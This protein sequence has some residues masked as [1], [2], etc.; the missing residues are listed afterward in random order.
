MAETKPSADFSAI[1]KE[2]EKL[3]KKWLEIAV[4]QEKATKSAEKVLT[5]FSETAKVFT[6]I[7]KGLK[8][9]A[10]GL[11]KVLQRQQ[12]LATQTESTT[13]A[14]KRQRVE[15][16]EQ[17]RRDA[18]YAGDL[19][20]RGF[21]QEQI[22]SLKAT[23][24][25]QVTYK[26]AIGRLREVLA[27]HNVGRE[28]IQQIW[29]ELAQGKTQAYT[30]SLRK[31]RDAFYDVK[32]AQEQLGLASRKQQAV[33][34]QEAAAQKQAQLAAEAHT[35]ALRAQE[36]AA[37]AQVLA[38]QRTIALTSRLMQGNVTQATMSRAQ[39]T[40]KEMLDYKN[41]FA[42]VK[43]LIA[44]HN[45]AYSQI[46]TIWQNLG[47]GVVTAYVGPLNQIQTALMKVKTTQAALGATASAQFNKMANAQA[48]AF[49]K[50]HVANMTFAKGVQQTKQAVDELVVGWR[51][52]VK[53][54]AVQLAHQA[55]SSLVRNIRDGIGTVVELGIRIG[56]VQTISQKLPLGVKEWIKGFRELSDTWGGKLL[57]QVAAG[58][59]TIS[60]QITEGA[61]T[62]RYLGEVNKFAV[63]AVSSTQE[64]AQLLNATINAFGLETSRA[65]E[66]A[67]SFFSTIDLGRVRAAEMAQTFGQIAVP[68]AQ[69]GVSLNELQ[70][71][72][73]T[74]SR[75]GIKYN[76]TATYLRNMFLKLIKPS[77]EM[78]KWFKQIG[79]ETAQ[80][81]IETF[82]F[83]PLLTMLSD[84]FGDDT[85]EIGKLMGRL[86]AMQ[87]AMST[88]G[89]NLKSV[90]KDFEEI[91]KAV[92]TYNEKSEF[93][94]ATP[95][96]RLQV[97]GER[98]RNF[99]TVDVGKEAIDALATL[100]SS[101]NAVTAG[102]KALFD[103]I[104]PALAAAVALTIK[105]ATVSKLVTFGATGLLGVATAVYA[106]LAFVKRLYEE[107]AADIDRL[108][109]ENQKNWLNREVLAINT[110]YDARKKALEELYRPTLQYFAYYR[111]LLNSSIDDY[112]EPYT[113]F[114]ESV[115]RLQEKIVDGVSEKLSIIKEEIN[116]Y[117]DIIS[118]K[119]KDFNKEMQLTQ[120][121]LERRLSGKDR[122]DKKEPETERKFYLMLGQLNILYA[123]LK[124][125]AQGATKERFESISGEIRKLVDTAIEYSD[126]FYE[127][128]GGKRELLRSGE[129]FIKYWEQIIL[130]QQGVMKSVATGNL[131]EAKKVEQYLEDEKS[132][133]KDLAK[134]VTETKW[135]ELNKI[136]DQEKLKETFD[137]QKDALQ[138]MEAFSVK[139]G[140]NFYR[141][142]QLALEKAKISELL[143]LKEQLFEL[144]RKEKMLRGAKEREEAEIEANRRIWTE[145]AVEGRKSVQDLATFMATKF[146]EAVLSSNP[147]TLFKNENWVRSFIPSSKNQGGQI[148]RYASGRSMGTDTV[149]AWL[150]PDEIV[151]NPQATRKFY[152]T[153]VAMNSS[154]RRFSSGGS[155][156]NNYNIGDINLSGQLS[157]DVGTNL[158][159]IGRGLQKQ[160]RLGRLRFAS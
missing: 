21:T 26:D 70:A 73:A 140:V 60:D 50:S 12:K 149:P 136:E 83:I 24:K 27:I 31:V 33:L 67:A 158:I 114:I 141:E 68:A 64:A 78:A 134:L 93:I 61:D 90:I 16:S 82:G 11:D 133:V 44:Q 101:F 65:N 53:L 29:N 99:F 89:R 43:K 142:A 45:L 54:A 126:K 105:W 4:A 111:S 35:R 130:T 23:P 17:G 79:V 69:L 152:S 30:G 91:T 135:T 75:Q 139:Y 7:T 96:K 76:T 58:Y 8:E 48:A 20:Q 110:A 155:V 106:T 132:R 47:K 3:V 13:A 120:R 121:I 112:E 85:A 25:E 39:A 97:V 34:A 46:K 147:G 117:E 71:L 42:T 160:V 100:G 6:E 94:M 104:L 98:L 119:Q 28:R 74:T 51:F 128:R 77:E 92:E 124:K 108:T 49:M 113:R 138:K 14:L 151:M 156:N 36:A 87:G 146:Q 10:G 1:F 56:E 157:N 40:P 118:T 18:K 9:A 32:V 125:A 19:V 59:E 55:I 137:K 102:A 129:A 145:F 37:R 131:Q 15:L 72:I 38:N 2:Q 84:R 88:T 57:D 95:E 127:E 123:E 148:P 80:A 5:K 143:M 41:A 122:F 116:R 153:L 103:L 66:I 107:R 63:T 86:R 150:S 144:E 22:S 81:A 154:Q 52:F 109:K 62:F 159:R 115:G